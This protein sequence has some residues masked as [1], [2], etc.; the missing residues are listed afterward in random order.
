MY[1]IFKHRQ[2]PCIPCLGETRIKLQWCNIFPSLFFSFFD[3]ATQLF[4]TPVMS[5][6]LC[7]Q[8][9]LFTELRLLQATPHRPNVNSQK[10]SSRFSVKAFK[11]SADWAL[12][13]SFW[14][15]LNFTHFK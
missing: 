10:V 3:F 9:P 4:S 11:E 14:D 1:K 2:L 15:D 7:N 5:S 6:N 8:A 12:F 13:S